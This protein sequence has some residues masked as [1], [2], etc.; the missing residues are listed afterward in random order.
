MATSTGRAR[1]AD[2]GSHASANP[3]PGAS[4]SPVKGFRVG[5][6]V[7]V[8]AG[9]VAAIVA[10]VLIAE[11]VIWG[12]GNSLGERY[13]QTPS[14]VS[15][16]ETA[17]PLLLLGSQ[18]LIIGGIEMLQHADDLRDPNRERVSFS[19][20]PTRNGALATMTTRF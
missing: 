11:A 20:A 7:L 3:A 17:G 4:R 5:G 13:D 1:E 14:W 6:A 9:V 16:F 19:L 18:P 10:D 2:G 15:S 12:I 8:V